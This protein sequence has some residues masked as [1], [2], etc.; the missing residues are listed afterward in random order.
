MSLPE[1]TSTGR[2]PEDVIFTNWII[3]Q[4]LPIINQCQIDN[5][6]KISKNRGRGNVQIAPTPIFG[7]F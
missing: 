4:S 6:C 3:S 2:T 7:D 1:L 5:L